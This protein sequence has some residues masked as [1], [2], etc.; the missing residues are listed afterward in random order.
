MVSTC[1]Y[2][3]ALPLRCAVAGPLT[4][5]T[6]RPASLPVAARCISI[7]T[8]M[9]TVGALSLSMAYPPSVVR[10]HTLN[11]LAA[12]GPWLQRM[13]DPDLEALLA[14]AEWGLGFT[15]GLDAKTYTC[16]AL[17]NLQQ[18]LVRFEKES[19]MQDNWQYHRCYWS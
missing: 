7:S 14:F 6:G 9:G 3:P 11:W 18:C 1:A 19:H 12:R 10:Y 13:S 17:S 4:S 8:A 15:L 16:R 2:A 5:G